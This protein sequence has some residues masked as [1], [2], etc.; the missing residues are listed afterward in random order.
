[1]L[2]ADPT[3]MIKNEVVAKVERIKDN[4]Q[5]LEQ[6]RI[7]HYLKLLQDKM[8]L[9]IG[10][11][12]YYKTYLDE[13]E[14]LYMGDLQETHFNSLALILPKNGNFYYGLVQNSQPVEKGI[15]KRKN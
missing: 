13:T 15:Y 1:M 5:I 4:F 11:I 14:N 2:A 7:P 9:R 10:M 3:I 12:K 6:L 8:D